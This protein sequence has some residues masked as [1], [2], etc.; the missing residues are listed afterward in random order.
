MAMPGRV[1]S[2][3]ARWRS[4]IACQAKG[5]AGNASSP[6]TIAAQIGAPRP[7]RLVAGT[8]AQTMATRA[9]GISTQGRRRGRWSSGRSRMVASGSCSLTPPPIPPAPGSSPGSA[10]PRPAARGTLARQLVAVVQLHQAH[11]AL[12]R[13][14]L[15]RRRD[16]DHGVAAAVQDQRRH[17]DVGPAARLLVQLR[18]DRRRVLEEA[19]VHPAPGAGGVVVDLQPAGLAP[20]A[21]RRLSQP[22]LPALDHPE[23]RRHQHQ[24]AHPGIRRRRQRRGQPAQAGSDH[25]RPVAGAADGRPGR[26]HPRAQ[27]QLLQR[28]QA[29]VQPIDAHPQAGEVFAEGDALAGLGTGGK[30]VEIQEPGTGHPRMIRQDPPLSRQVGAHPPAGRTAPRSP[31][32]PRAPGR[33]SPR[34]RS[35]R[36]WRR[37]AGPARR[38]CGACAGR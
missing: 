37:R 35:G 13:G 17:A 30:T 31:R 25:H 11:V 15:A 4:A 20:V 18:L 8:S 2:T 21:Q 29:Q 16:V 33:R 6:A 23:R 27:P 22:R 10:G 3:G 5:R 36:R 14:E 26:G 9:Q 12:A 28:R 19:E 1:R 38:P 7:R 34:W 32:T 24:R